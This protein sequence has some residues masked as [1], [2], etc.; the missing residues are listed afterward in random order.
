MPPTIQVLLG[1][2]I[3]RLRAR[4]AQRAGARRGDRPPVLARALA[5]LLPATPPI[6]TRASKRCAAAS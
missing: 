3:E 1:A 2:R 4:G 5:E 6:S